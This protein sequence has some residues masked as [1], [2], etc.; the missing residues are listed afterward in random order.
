MTRPSPRKVAGK[1]PYGARRLWVVERGGRPVSMS[2]SVM[3]ATV[4]Y[5]NWSMRV[6][7]EVCKD[8][9]D[10]IVEYVPSLPRKAKGARR[11]K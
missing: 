8:A 11:G 5:A 6:G 10:R 1:V 9:T 7:H 2:A 4:C 3:G